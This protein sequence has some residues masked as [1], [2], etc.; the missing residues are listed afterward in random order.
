MVSS[1][2]HDVVQKTQETREATATNH[3]LRPRPERPNS[4][5]AITNEENASYGVTGDFLSENEG[6]YCN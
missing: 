3:N 6:M 2:S 1:C 4:D 5:I